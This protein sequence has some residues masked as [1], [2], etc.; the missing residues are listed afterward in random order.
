MLQQIHLQQN[1]SAHVPFL[2]TNPAV[3]SLAHAVSCIIQLFSSTE[4]PA[5]CIKAFA[6]HTS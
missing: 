6:V 4:V 1:Y 3:L 5:K 2:G